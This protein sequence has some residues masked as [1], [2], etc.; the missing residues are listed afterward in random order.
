[1]SDIDLERW[2]QLAA[3]YRAPM[4]WRLFYTRLLDGI[5][6]KGKTVL[7]IGGGVG[8]AATYALA[9]GANEAVLLEPEAAGSQ[10]K[11]LA[12]ARSLRDDLSLGDRFDIRPDTLQEFDGSG[13]PFDVIIM[14]ASINHLDEDAVI[15]L[16][17]SDASQARYRAIGKK[18]ASLLRP[19]GTIVISDCARHNFFGDIGLRNPFVP[20]IDWPKHQQPST[21]VKLF[22]PCGFSSPRVRWG[23]HAT[24][25][26]LGR[27][28]LGNAFVFYFLSSYF[29]LSL[30]YQ[31]AGR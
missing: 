8:L 24:L 7:D 15:T 31:H 9:H 1:M 3:K 16:L 17:T 23:I 26:P 30:R 20:S 2:S 5:D 6:F 18:L 21:W 14:E 29:I 27:F 4:N 28:F 10:N 13:A 12:R 11:Q 22:E 19:G 25:G